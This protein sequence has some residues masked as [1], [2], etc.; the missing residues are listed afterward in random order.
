MR[1][2]ETSERKM[3]NTKV[4]LLMLLLAASVGMCLCLDEDVVDDAKQNAGSAMHDAEKTSDSGADRPH[5]KSSKYFHSSPYILF[6]SSL[7]FLYLIKINF[8]STRV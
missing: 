7:I 5:D 3:A 4:L 8:S 1:N 2:E 6:F